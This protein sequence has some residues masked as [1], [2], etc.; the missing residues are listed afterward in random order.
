MR[1]FSLP[2][3]YTKKEIFKTVGAISLE[4][5]TA[6][7]FDVE[8]TY[9]SSNRQVRNTLWNKALWMMNHDTFPAVNLHAKTGRI[10]KREKYLINQEKNVQNAP[11]PECPS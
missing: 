1:E 2:S 6:R 4:V 5:R 8:M 7:E 11:V 10:E 9:C 3:D